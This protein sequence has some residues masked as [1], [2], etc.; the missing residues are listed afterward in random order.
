M[1]R[2]QIVEGPD[3]WSFHMAHI[4]GGG[5]PH[6]RRNVR[7]T[8]EN[9]DQIEVVL[10]ELARTGTPFNNF[11]SVW[12]FKGIRRENAEFHRW[13]E[14]KVSMSSAIALAGLRRWMFLLAFPA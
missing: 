5:I 9:G 2:E 6:Q 14:C 11:E 4:E 13:H 1:A 7:F 3:R 12:R 8:L 10:N